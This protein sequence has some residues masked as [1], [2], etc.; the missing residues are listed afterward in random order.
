MRKY[1]YAITSLLTIFIMFVS[2]TIPASA[3]STYPG[4]LHPG[5]MVVDDSEMATFITNTYFNTETGRPPVT[6]NNYSLMC[7]VHLYYPAGDTYQCTYFYYDSS[8]DKP[9]VTID[10]SGTGYY[11]LVF[12]YSYSGML[13]QTTGQYTAA[14]YSGSTNFPFLFDKPVNPDA[15]KFGN[16]PYGTYLTDS[17]YHSNVLS[18]K[19]YTTP[20]LTQ[21]GGDWLSDIDFTDLSQR[22][23]VT[24]S[25]YPPFMLDM[26]RSSP[27]SAGAP[28]DSWNYTVQNNSSLPIQYRAWVCLA[29]SS[30]DVYS[31]DKRVWSLLRK[32]WVYSV[33]LVDEASHYNRTARKMFMA[34]EWQ[35]VPA[36]GKVTQPVSWSC[37]SLEP[38]VEYTL[39]FEAVFCP[40][41]FPS[42]CLVGS[43]D[44]VYTDLYQFNLNNHVFQSFDFSLLSVVPYS[45]VIYY[46]IIPNIGIDGY[47]KNLYKYDAYEDNDGNVIVSSGDLYTDPDSFIYKPTIDGHT[48]QIYNKSD[49]Y[50]IDVG[51]ISI[52]DISELFDSTIPFLRFMKHAF[53]TLPGF[54]W[55]LFSGSILGC[56]VLRI[57]GR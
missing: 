29:D 57:L 56:I 33:D 43:A 4:N 10:D 22:P 37:L 5:S 50:S 14:G 45:D 26:D 36:K 40:W 7:E 15:G 9:A 52:D 32:Q 47:R 54:V 44:E 21:L 28:L 25:T 35:R 49:D 51:A 18:V 3:A 48:G 17:T 31:S 13:N 23:D 38:G 34:S 42:D 19:W 1:V 16:L 27:E 8:K 2:L 30:L 39:C 46:G 12:P 6:Y 11:K 20:D 41:D 55:V 53:A 24:F